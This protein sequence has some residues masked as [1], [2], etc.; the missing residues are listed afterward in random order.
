MTQTT[1]NQR[2]SPAAVFICDYCGTAK[3]SRRLCSTQYLKCVGCELTTRHGLAGV[4]TQDGLTAHRDKDWREAALVE[5]REK[6]RA[7]LELK[8]IYTRL[9][10]DIVYADEILNS[11]EQHCYA[12]VTRDRRD[13][14]C[15]TVTISMEATPDG[16]KKA[17]TDA[18]GAFTSNEHLLACKPG[19]VVSRCWRQPDLIAG[20]AA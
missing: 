12:A 3:A 20:G 13:G 4:R 16:V 14:D 10:I 15:W 6:T 9:G 2:T 18:I 8:D 5:R 17:L 11:R 19:E 7:L 1:A